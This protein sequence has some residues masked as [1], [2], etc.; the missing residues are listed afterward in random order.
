MHHGSL[1]RLRLFPHC[2][3][4]VVL[5]GIRSFIRARAR[6]P[7]SRCRGSRE[8]AAHVEAVTRARGA[9]DT[10]ASTLLRLICLAY[11]H[12]PTPGTR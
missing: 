8:R 3:F 7:Q 9:R 2:K 4:R 12:W 5:K 1:A 11:I 6:A 10:E